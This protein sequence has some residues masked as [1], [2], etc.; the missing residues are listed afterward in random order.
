M[1]TRPR[2]RRM[3]TLAQLI[4]SSGPNWKEMKNE[5][6]HC[7]PELLQFSRQGE[8]VSERSSN[9]D[10]DRFETWRSFHH[11][12]HHHHH[13]HQ[14]CSMVH[15]SE[16]LSCPIP[17]SFCSYICSYKWSM[18]FVSSNGIVSI[19]QGTDEG[20]LTIFYSVDDFYYTL[21]EVNG[22]V[23]EHY[24]KF[25]LWKLRKYL[26]PIKLLIAYQL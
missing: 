3:N 4:N 10:F 24:N 6:K 16:S 11:D 9:N 2:T 19:V 15:C 12:D 26:Q 18:C 1:L 20:S 5:G 7:I 25:C 21:E 14:L 22:N 17:I 13:H 8:G 23:K